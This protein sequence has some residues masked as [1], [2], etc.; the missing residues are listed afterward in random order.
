MADTD[1]RSDEDK[2]MAERR[3]TDPGIYRIGEAVIWD[4]EAETL[5]VPPK[6]TMPL[7]PDEDPD[8]EA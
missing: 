7:P 1:N 2:K 5:D 6:T 3:M 8:A 4:G